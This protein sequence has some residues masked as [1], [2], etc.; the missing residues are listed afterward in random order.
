MTP[1]LEISLDRINQSEAGTNELIA[2]LFNGGDYL[3][4]PNPK[5]D[6]F[7]NYAER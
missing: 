3:D 7:V 4:K 2:N 1:N 5:L 6:D